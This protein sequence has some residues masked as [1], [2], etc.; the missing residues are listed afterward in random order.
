MAERRHSVDLVPPHPPRTSGDAQPHTP[1]HARRPN[2]CAGPPTYLLRRCM[3][4]GGRL[5]FSI[6]PRPR[7]PTYPV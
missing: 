6:Q 1:S 5:R 4:Q 2:P 7:G 3:V